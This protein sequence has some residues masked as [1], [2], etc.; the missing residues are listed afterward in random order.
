[1]VATEAQAEKQQQQKAGGRKM[2]L[3]ELYLNVS[4]AEWVCRWGG[5]GGKWVAGVGVGGGGGGGGHVGGLGKMTRG[6]L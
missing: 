1:M 2:T 6:E 4:C 5:G 3:E